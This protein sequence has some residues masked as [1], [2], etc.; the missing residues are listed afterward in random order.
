MT[1]FKEQFIDYV[2]MEGFGFEALKLVTRLTVLF[3]KDKTIFCRRYKCIWLL[4]GLKPQQ[5][6]LFEA[7]VSSFNE[8]RNSFKK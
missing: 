3:L 6:Q 1:F 5:V 4:N 8:T 2:H 7:V